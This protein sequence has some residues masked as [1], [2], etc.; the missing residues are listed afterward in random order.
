METISPARAARGP[1]AT[2]SPRPSP[3]HEYF[4]G[5][6]GMRL[7]ASNQTG[8]SALEAVLIEEQAEVDKA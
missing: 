1:L 2:P 4:R 8:S 3:I 6:N 5:D 7:G